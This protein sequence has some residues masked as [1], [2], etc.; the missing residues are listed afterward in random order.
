M[1][2]YTFT[3]V[4]LVDPDD[5][6]VSRSY[7]GDLATCMSK[8]NSVLRSDI[9]PITLAVSIAD[10][11]GRVIFHETTRGVDA[12]IWVNVMGWDMDYVMP[13]FQQFFK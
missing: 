3:L 5:I 6:I 12:L 8:Y 11:N 2:N 7:T 13:L 9:R 4:A 10:S 1:K